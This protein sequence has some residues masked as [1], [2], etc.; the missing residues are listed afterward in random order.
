M[1][2]ILLG[3]R[4]IFYCHKYRLI[5]VCPVTFPIANSGPSCMLDSFVLPQSLQRYLLGHLKYVCF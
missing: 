4:E 3:H 5:C 1:L 2:I